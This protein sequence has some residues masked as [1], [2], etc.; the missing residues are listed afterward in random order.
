MNDQR[1]EATLL[2]CPFCGHAPEL[3]ESIIGDGCYIVT[4]GNG[5]CLTKP[6]LDRAG[7]EN[8]VSAWNTRAR[9]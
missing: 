5:R 1:D 7:K 3:F 2:P 4:C 8:A 6:S 9:S